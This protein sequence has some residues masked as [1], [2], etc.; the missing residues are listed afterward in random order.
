MGLR[1]LWCSAWFSTLCSALL[2]DPVVW[3]SFPCR[4]L[5]FRVSA[6]SD[7]VCLA[8]CCA[9]GLGWAATLL[10]CSQC[11]SCAGWL[12]GVRWVLLPVSGSSHGGCACSLGGSVVVPYGSPCLRALFLALSSPPAV[13]TL[14]GCCALF[15][16]WFPLP[17]G[18]C[19]SGLRCLRRQFAVESA[20]SAALRG[21]SS[22]SGLCW[23]FTC[24]CGG[25]VWS[26]V[27][28]PSCCSG[29]LGSCGASVA[30]FCRLG[31]LR[32]LPC[33]VFAWGF[34]WFRGPSSWCFLGL[35]TGVLSSR[36]R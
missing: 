10:L 4:R 21:W 18:G 23:S 32:A 1:C 7:T 30:P 14:C 6:F 24:S 31:L 19:A 9:G 26:Q 17:W 13:L 11:F 35:F 33:R 12:A 25:V 20:V 36:F 34:L 3:G 5:P 28:G 8:Y 27:C 15:I 2:P 29:V 22:F 16:A